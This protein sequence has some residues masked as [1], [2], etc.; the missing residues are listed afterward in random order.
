MVVPASAAVLRVFALAGIDRLVPNFANLNEALEQ[1][2]AVV[3]RPLHR[4]PLP[5]PDAGLVDV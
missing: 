5:P 3:P 2:Q 4:Y 1:A